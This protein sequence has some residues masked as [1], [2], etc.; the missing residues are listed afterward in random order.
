MNAPAARSLRGLVPEA[1]WRA[2]LDLAACYRLAALHG[3]TDLVYTHISARVPG[4]LEHFLLNPFG[5]AFDEITAS[6]LAKIDLDGA[7]VD[8]PADREPPRIHR[9]GFVIHSAVHGAR[10]EVGCVIHTHTRAGMAVSMLDCGLLPLSQHAQLFH[11]RV[12]YHA[13]EGLATE[14]EERERLVRDLGD[15]SVLILR[16]HGLLVAGRTVAEAFSMCFHL[17]KACDAQLAAMACGTAL[18][19][20]GDA[21]SAKTAARG[22]GNPASPLGRDEWPAMLRRLDRIDPGWRD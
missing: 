12:G 5:L 3:W 11:G 7:L 13:Y 15:R 8:A 20:P 1:E 19:V 22:F 21:V 6:S 18:S 2:R 10:P 14:L 9:A 4:P 17:E 16:N